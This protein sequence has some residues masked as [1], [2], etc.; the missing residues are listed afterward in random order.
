MCGLNDAIIR[1]T[2]V[3]GRWITS[4]NHDERFD[5]RAGRADPGDVNV[6]ESG[7][8]PRTSVEEVGR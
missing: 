5:R 4:E 6:S 7:P 1:L 8:L 2:L 3:S